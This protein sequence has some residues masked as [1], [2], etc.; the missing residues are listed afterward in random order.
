M[1][2]E[3]S[4]NAIARAGGGVSLPQ[5]PGQRWNPI[6]KL[7]FATL[8]RTREHEGSVFVLS[9][10]KKPV[11]KKL[12]LGVTDGATTELISGDLKAGDEVIVGDGTQPETQNQV[13]VQRGQGQ[14]QRGQR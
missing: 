3:N 5:A 6:E 1:A 4:E 2:T 8:E 9:A 13:N 11:E 7:R 12:M 14:P 10:E